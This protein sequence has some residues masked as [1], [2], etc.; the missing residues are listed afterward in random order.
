V[1]TTPAPPLL[2]VRTFSDD[3]ALTIV[4]QGEADVANHD[5]L[6]MSL[7]GVELRGTRTV[8]L[9]LSRLVFCDLYGFRELIAFAAHARRWGVETLVTGARP[10]VR[11][12]AQI[13]GTAGDVPFEPPG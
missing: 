11:K 1:P 9:D 6:R 4:L 12:M 7:D 8:M 13:L 3:D 2:D 10:V 5:L